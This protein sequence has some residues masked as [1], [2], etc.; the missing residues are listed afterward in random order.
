MLC[1]LMV[2]LP[3]DEWTSLTFLCCIYEIFFFSYIWMSVCL[4]CLLIGHM[5][6]WPSYTFVIFEHLARVFYI[7]KN[8]HTIFCFKAI[9][10]CLSVNQNKNVRNT[11]I[12]FSWLKLPIPLPSNITFSVLLAFYFT[13]EKCNLYRKDI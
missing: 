1:F 6:L 2:V 12:L 9:R 7:S 3:L 10:S 5:R 13:T 8:V 11:R 4:L